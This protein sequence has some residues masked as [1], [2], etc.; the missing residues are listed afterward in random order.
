M[1]KDIIYIVPV[2]I[3]PKMGINGVKIPVTGVGMLSPLGRG[4]KAVA[5]ARGN[6]SSSINNFCPLSPED[7]GATGE[8]SEKGWRATLLALAAS[9]MALEQAFPFESEP[10]RRT[11]AIFGTSLIDLSALERYLAAFRQE[12]PQAIPAWA[13]HYALPLAH[14]SHAAVSLRLTGMCETLNDPITAGISAVGMG[15]RAVALGEE[16]SLLAGGVDSPSD[17]IFLD[18]LAEALS[19]RASSGPAEGCAVFHLQSQEPNSTSHPSKAVAYICGYAT[20]FTEGKR[21]RKEALIDRLAK[22][23]FPDGEGVDLVLDTATLPHPIPQALAGGSALACGLAIS[24]MGKP[25]PEFAQKLGP[26]SSFPRGRDNVRRVIVTAEGPAGDC[27]AIAFSSCQESSKTAISRRYVSFADLGNNCEVA[28]KAVIT[29]TG[30]VST[31]GVGRDVF[32]EALISGAS[33]VVHYVPPGLEGAGPSTAALVPDFQTDAEIQRSS[34]LAFAATE[35]ALL[36]AGLGKEPAIG[37]YLGET[38]PSVEALEHLEEVLREENNTSE[39][40]ALADDALKDIRESTV[41]RVAKRFGLSG[42]VLTFGSG[43]TGGLFALGRA[44]RDVLEGT[45]PLILAGSSESNLFPFAFGVLSRAKLLTSCPDPNEAGRPFDED[46]DGE[47]TA[48]GSAMFVVE[49]PDS[50]IERGV[51]PY[52]IVSGFGTAGEAYHFK[53]NKMDGE[54]LT[55]ASK[56]AL[57]MAGL[58]ASEIDLVIAHASGFKRSD[59]IEVRALANL[60]NGCKD[61]P[62]VISIKG[63]TGQAFSAGGMFQVAAALCAFEKG[64]IPPTVHF[65]QADKDDPFDHVPTARKAEGPIRHILITSYGYGGGKAALVLSAH[66]GAR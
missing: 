1:A 52:A 61:F 50:A 14:A 19:V 66:E 4:E 26:R 20:A 2:H 48:E 46:R 49:H 40:G 53:Y 31:I 12:G 34:Q 16:R 35:E 32:Y 18:S 17:S 21:E 55:D 44:A 65:K 41:S 30:I 60:F 45:T 25:V 29:G 36:D 33:G 63:A 39:N 11:G 47:V 28:P 56:M 43:C 6:H 13:L 9:R 27:A 10:D 24:S 22:E 15:Y 7:H 54:A 58:D 8:L 42:E 3:I 23:S 59:A 62:P 38:L 37:L 57:N 64:I 51:K 5:T